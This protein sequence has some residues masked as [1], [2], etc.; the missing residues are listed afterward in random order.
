MNT[1]CEIQSK[2]ELPYGVIELRSDNILAFRPTVGVFKEF[3]LTILKELHK[4]F[5]TITEGKP[6]PYLSDNRYITG[7]IDKKEQR[8]IKENFSDF[9]TH[10]AIITHSPVMKIILNAYNS[11]FKPKVEVRLFTSEEEAIDWLLN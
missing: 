8:F 7:L 6:R 2:K 10:S 3:D 1:S 9:A 11:I 4:E 5:I